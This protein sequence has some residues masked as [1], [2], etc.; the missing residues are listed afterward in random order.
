MHSP[1]ANPNPLVTKAGTILLRSTESMWFDIWKGI[2]FGG[3]RSRI[4]AYS[5]GCI[6]L[7]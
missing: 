7:F 2:E 5:A 4:F 6:P 1:M 3:F